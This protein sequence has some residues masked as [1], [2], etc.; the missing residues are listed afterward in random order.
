MCNGNEREGK[1]W[2][3]NSE[4][5]WRGELLK[6]LRL[7]WWWAPLQVSISRSTPKPLL[8]C[9]LL[10]DASRDLITKT[11]IGQI[12]STVHML[13]D[14]STRPQE[15]GNQDSTTLHLCVQMCWSLHG[16]SLRTVNEG[17]IVRGHYLKS[18]NNTQKPG[19]IFTLQLYIYSAMMPL[20]KLPKVK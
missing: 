16:Y 4:W 1:Q 11:L 18:A 2:T 8:W 12:S 15:T 19:L 10:A 5:D 13:L 7:H 3:V 6:R 9:C 20:K 17:K 14:L